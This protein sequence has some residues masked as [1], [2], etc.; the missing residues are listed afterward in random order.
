ML[1]RSLWLRLH[2]RDGESLEGTAPNNLL[3]NEPSGFTI[4]PPDPTFQNQRVFVPREALT[5]IEVLG[6]IGSSLRRP[7]KP[8][9]DRDKQLQMF[10]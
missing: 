6:V 1:F 7:A 8:Q 2:F 10:E 3:Q 5:R 4:T 9:P